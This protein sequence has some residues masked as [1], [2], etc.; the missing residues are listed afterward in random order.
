MDYE[1]FDEA[2]QRVFEAAKR[3]VE[4]ARLRPEI[5]RLRSLAGQ[6]NDA[7]DRADA[8]HD[9]EMLEDLVATPPAQPVSPALEAANQAYAVAVREGGTPVER[10]QRV[11]RGIE[12]LS[13]LVAQADPDDQ[14]SIRG[15]N[16]SLYSLASALQLMPD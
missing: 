5:E 15:L 8:G 4:A 3:G 10:I 7:A 16:E 11:Q 1:Q 6:L 2:Y 13:R 9:I 12:E 14:T